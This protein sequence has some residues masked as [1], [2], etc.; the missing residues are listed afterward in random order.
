MAEVIFTRS[1]CEVLSEANR[2]RTDLSAERS[3]IRERLVQLDRDIPSSGTS[4]LGLNLHRH[5]SPLHLTSIWY[6]NRFNGHSVRQIFLRYGK[7]RAEMLRPEAQVLDADVDGQIEEGPSFMSHIH[8]S[9]GLD[10]RGFFYQIIMQPDAVADYDR[11]LLMLRDEGHGPP[12]LSNLRMLEDAGYGLF[13]GDESLP[14][15]ASSECAAGLAQRLEQEYGHLRGA[16]YFGTRMDVQVVDRLVISTE[17][18][19]GEIH[20]MFPAFNLIR[21]P[22][23]GTDAVRRPAPD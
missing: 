14:I 4:V 15:R 17:N 10:E 18:L 19:I 16:Y 5:W 7:S 21:E 20:R 9:T 13:F 3:S 1:D 6:P 22:L 23:G 12:L 8:L 2:R 11:F